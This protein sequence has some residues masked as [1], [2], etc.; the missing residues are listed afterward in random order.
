MGKS[1]GG[2]Q[3]FGA[4]DAQ[5]KREEEDEERK[6]RLAEM[7]SS[8]EQDKRE[9]YIPYCV[10]FISFVITLDPMFV[11]LNKARRGRNAAERS[12]EAR[13]RYEKRQ[14]NQD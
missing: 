9:A 10:F 6:Q 5:Q 14:G 1:K 7:A 8:M 3:L 4:F 12:R 2:E 13:K 11:L